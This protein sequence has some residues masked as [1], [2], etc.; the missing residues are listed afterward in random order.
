M[1]RRILKAT[2]GV[3]AAAT[4]I[5]ATAPTSASAAEQQSRV[6]AVPTSTTAQ[7]IGGSGFELSS[8]TSRWT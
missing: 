5:A 8:F 3:I 6:T 1:S 4:T 2:I 7:H